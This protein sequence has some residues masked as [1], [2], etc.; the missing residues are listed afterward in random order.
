MKNKVYSIDI[1]VIIPSFN[2]P[3]DYLN[4]CIQSITTQDFKEFEII[5][6][7]DGS[8]LEYRKRMD[9]LAKQNFN[10]YV[11]HQAN[12][13]VSAARNLGIELAKGK[14]ITFVDA[15]D[16]LGNK[17]LSQSFSLAESLEADI[18]YGK[19]CR[20]LESDTKEFGYLE[21]ENIKTRI[22]KENEIWKVKRFLLINNTESP[23]EEMKYL[24]L[25]PYG[26]L[27][28]KS[29]FH[30][31][32]FPSHLS[33]GEDQVFN[34]KI[35]CNAR[36]CVV[37]NAN[38]Y[39]YIQNTVSVSHCY[40]EKAVDILMDSMIEIRDVLPDILIN[41][42]YYCV[43]MNFIVAL[44]IQL[45]RKGSPCE[46]F[47]Q[48]IRGIKMELKNPVVKEALKNVDLKKIHN[49]KT[50]IKVLLMKY[51]MWGLWALYME[52]CM[53]LHK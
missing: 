28:R 27:F 13:G 18:V 20:V 26:K 14:Y 3:I 5:L 12:K 22:F 36:C 4:R 15:D 47:A 16:I 53:F 35:L 2:T 11:V 17:W 48:R 24:D 37:C 25:G 44:S 50:K 9:E 38:A 43:I 10:L 46:S 51:K 7:D 34:H 45:F 32:N 31:V 8:D 49:S 30:D 23:I 33:L 41:E 1:S 19:V 6:I 52:S 40:K 21:R 29:I 42:Y 39:Y